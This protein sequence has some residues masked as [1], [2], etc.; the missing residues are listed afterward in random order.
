MSTIMP[1]IN[2][3]LN[4]FGLIVVL[5]VMVACITERLKKQLTG[6]AYFLSLVIL[7]SISLAF[8]IV[9][10]IGEGNAKL[11]VLNLVF[12]TL[13]SCAGQISIM[14]FLEYLCDSLYV[15]NKKVSIVMYAFRYLC[16]ASLLFT[17]GNAFFGYSFAFST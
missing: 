3:A 15:N 16:V 5:I 2:I 6:P 13:A 10:W 4:S 14:C 1:Y 7:V 11:G 9:C 17:V 8:D 12:N